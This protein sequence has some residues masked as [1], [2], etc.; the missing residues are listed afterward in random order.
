MHLFLTSIYSVYGPFVRP[1]PYVR[2]WIHW[3]ERLIEKST[4]LPYL[5]GDSER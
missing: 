3:L 4:E 1:N 5:H 2:S